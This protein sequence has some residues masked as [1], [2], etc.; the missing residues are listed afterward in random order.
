MILFTSEV[1]WLQVVVVGQVWQHNNQTIKKTSMIRPWFRSN[2]EIKWSSYLCILD[3]DFSS[4]DDSNDDD[5]EL[6]ARPKPI[7][8]A[9]N[10]T[11]SACEEELVDA[12][13]PNDPVDDEQSLTEFLERVKVFK[14]SPPRGCWG[15]WWDDEG[16]SD[17]SSWEPFD[18]SSC[19][20]AASFSDSELEEYL[21]K[22]ILVLMIQKVAVKIATLLQILLLQKM[23]RTP[24]TTLTL[25]N[26]T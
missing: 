23:L 6:V 7:V 25:K 11:L 12:P 21:G 13:G 19:S 24:M 26:I 9:K 8:A 15:R 20:S 2:Q 14:T 3:P 17:L 18:S 10:Q 1:R 16:I 5:F 4:G 22:I